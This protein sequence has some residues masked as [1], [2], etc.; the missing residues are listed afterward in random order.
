[1]KK[2]LAAVVVLSALAALGYWYWKR[3]RPA[4]ELEL[5][6]TIEARTVEVGSLTGGRVARVLVHEGDEVAA[7]QPL[8]ELETT[9]SDATVAE[10]QAAV[11]AARATLEG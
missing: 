10:Q 11:A 3:S 1:M 9:M 4:P 2:A 6:G 7:G 5:A 8:I